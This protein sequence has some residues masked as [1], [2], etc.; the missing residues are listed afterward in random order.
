MTRVFQYGT[1]DVFNYGDLL[2]PL[3]ARK[4]LASCKADVVAL[5][6]AGGPPVLSDCLA[7]AGVASSRNLPPA[8]A[9]LIGGG[10]IIDIAPTRTPVYPAEAESAL[11]YPDLWLTAA[12][13][14]LPG[15][16]VC[17]NAPGVP[18]P[19][20]G[21]FR[22]YVANCLR[23]S[24]YV[25]V[26]DDESRA[27]LLEALPEADVT[28]VPDTAWEID[29]LWDGPD[30]QQ[31]RDRA[32]RDRG[33]SPCSRILAVHLNSRYLSGLSDTA[34]AALLDRM[35]R[36]WDAR[37][38]LIAVGACHGDDE[39]CRRIGSDMC[40]APLVVDRP[41]SLLEIAS[42]IAGAQGYAG[43]SMHGLIT[44]LAFGIPGVCVSDGRKPK[45]HGLQRFVNCEEVL[46]TSWEAALQQLE[47]VAGADAK[48][49]WGPARARARDQLNEHWRRITELIAQASCRDKD[50]PSAPANLAGEIDAYR[51]QLADAIAMENLRRYERARKP[52]TWAS[53]ENPAAKPTIPAAE[54]HPPVTTPTVDILMATYCGE[55]FVREQID[56]VFG[57]SCRD[58]RLIVRDDGST[59][60]TRAILERYARDHPGRIVLLADYERLGA[61]ANFA[62]LLEHARSPYVMFCDQDDVWL[63]K[64][65]EL[66]LDRMRLVEEQHGANRPVLL[67]TDL[68]PVHRDLR[69]MGASYWQVR[70]LS[71]HKVA[72]PRLLVQN[73]PM[74]CTT[75]LNRALANQCIPISPAAVMHDH[76]VTLVA[77]AIGVLHYLDEVTV[78]YRQHA[79][80]QTGSEPHGGR[81]FLRSL[82]RGLGAYR[83]RC[84]KY[85]DQAAA[86]R[87]RFGNR[88]SAEDRAA[89]SALADL[90]STGRVGR[91]LRL[92]RRGVLKQGLLRNLA[93]FLAV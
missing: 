37:I 57:Q 3:V 40:S 46:A 50:P 51:A 27:A 91:R 15:V 14:A 69:P 54:E 61:C 85:V 71:P 74:G 59:D 1:F 73:V 4:R 86:L 53:L 76:W 84:Y 32:F 81:R 78:L 18:G 11:G 21:S 23:R 42:L 25:S 7:S 64:K 26:R 44:A 66:S 13:A 28:V 88:L 29:G 12:R 43:S 56:S 49:H 80:N 30:L 35:S 41:R 33:E 31:S 24:D 65:I 60:G 38:A 82:R 20:C 39:L 62:R 63:P 93:Q 70:G 16:P 77:A 34:I 83:A 48:A 67:Y 6:P 75:V 17:W 5:S 58:W 90:R 87:D 52:G 2:F 8:D 68:V 92:L 89:V 9:V 45:F 10:N 47:T 55:A 36:H 22:P 79:G 19:F 72:L